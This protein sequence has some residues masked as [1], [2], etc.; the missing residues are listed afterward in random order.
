MGVESGTYSVEVQRVDEVLLLDRKVVLRQE[1]LVIV[2]VVV[3]IARRY[4]LLV[5][6]LTA[7]V[8]ASLLLGRKRARRSQRGAGI[9]S[10]L[11]SRV[12]PLSREEL[13]SC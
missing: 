1:A 10:N 8:E 11:V 13:A 6:E 9:A 5:E 3:L 2:E 7:A 12:G 4:C